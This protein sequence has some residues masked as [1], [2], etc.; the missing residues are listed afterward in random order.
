ML[1][2]GVQSSGEP[3]AGLGFFSK[4][5]NR[6]TGKAELSAEDLDPVLE[7][8]RTTVRRPHKHTQGIMAWSGLLQ[9]L[10]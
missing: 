9:T 4:Y 7:D 3:A 8:M 10:V 6:I 5:F 1:C 2:L